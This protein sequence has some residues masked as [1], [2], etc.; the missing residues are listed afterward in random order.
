MHVTRER[1]RIAKHGARNNRR[2]EKAMQRKR[3]KLAEL[4]YEFKRERERG[5]EERQKERVGR[6]RKM[7]IYLCSSVAT[8]TRVD[9]YIGTKR[10]EKKRQI[11]RLNM[12]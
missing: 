9:M 3:E 7:S 12:C 4:V 2:N 8:K 5:E 6:N 1:A 10:N 11:L